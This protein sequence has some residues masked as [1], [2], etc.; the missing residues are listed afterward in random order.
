VTAT[1]P[2]L[3][4][5]QVSDVS[6]ERGE[7]RLTPLSIGTYTVEYALPGFQT[8]RREGLRLTAGFVAKVDVVLKI[9]A[10]AETITVSGAAPVVDVTSTA[11]R[12]QLTREALESVPVGRSGYQALLAQAPGVRTNLDVGG[13]T[14]ATNPS[15]R[16]FGQNG[17]SWST[18]EGV[19]TTSPKSGT[20]GG[21]YFDYASV[22]EATVQT[23][24]NNADS[25]T[26]G[27]QLNVILKSGGN[28]FHGLGFFAQT[29]RGMVDNNIDDALRAQGITAGNPVKNRWDVNADLGGRIVR[30]KLWFYYSGRARDRPK[31]CSA[32]F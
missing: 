9:G 29:T 30:N 31:T 6:N 3:Q 5:P 17:D 16:V 21:N 27:V 28:D 20:Q 10:V 26:H 1:S 19:L 15:F 8:V 11:S 32:A 2:S 24:G 12:T 22:E 13:N 23:A 4:V 14:T 7:Y 25:A 18:L